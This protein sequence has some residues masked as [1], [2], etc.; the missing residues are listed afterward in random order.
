[1]FCVFFHQLQ[2]WTT[3]QPGTSS[4]P[5]LLML[6]ARVFLQNGLETARITFESMLGK[7]PWAAVLP[8]WCWATKQ[9]GLATA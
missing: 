5:V 8:G 7:S 1:M 4:H 3:K 9:D 6:G 2:V